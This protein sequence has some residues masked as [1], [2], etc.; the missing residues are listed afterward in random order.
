[1]VPL[2]GVVVN[3][4]KNDFDPGRVQRPHHELKLFHRPLRRSGEARIGS[5]E[6][7]RVVAP[8]VDEA[9]LQQMS[10]VEVIVDRQKLHGRDAEGLQMIDGGLASQTGIPP[11]QMLR[12]AR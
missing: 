9:P 1:M 6:P 8:I 7:Q 4:I 12:Y 5:E 3:N 11:A 10:V 2:G